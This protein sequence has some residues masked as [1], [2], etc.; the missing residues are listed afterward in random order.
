MVWCSTDRCYYC[1][2]CYRDGCMP[3]H[4][5]GPAI[6]RQNR[7]LGFV[8]LLMLGPILA[9]VGLALVLESFVPGPSGAVL[10][11]GFVLIGAPGF[12]A[13]WFLVSS[14]MREHAHRAS[15][16]ARPPATVLPDDTARDP[17]LPWKP[18]QPTP[19][20]TKR[21]LIAVTIFCVAAAVAL[22]AWFLAVGS[23]TL[24]F[25]VAALGGL[26]LAIATVTGF[27]ASRPIAVPSAV[28]VAH[29]GIHFSYD[30]PYD[31]R[32]QIP[33]MPWTE[34]NILGMQGP[35]LGDPASRLV[36][37]FRIDG[38][39]AQEITRAWESR[40]LV[41]AAPSRPSPPQPATSAAPPSRG[42]PP[43]AVLASRAGSGGPGGRGVACARCHVLFPGIEGLRLL[44]CK[45]DRF[46]VCRRCW[47]DGCQEGHGRGVRSVSKTSRVVS[48]AVVAALFFALW[49]PG[50]AY[51]DSLTNAW[52]YAPVT[53]IAALHAGQ[54][55]KVEGVI[56]SDGLIAFGGQEIIQ[57][58]S[59]NWEWNTFDSFT[60]VDLTGS[61][62]VSTADWYIV[63]NGPIAAPN[64]YHVQA[65]DYVPGDYVQIVGTVVAAANG[66]LQLDLQIIAQSG[67]VGFITLTPSLLSALMV[68]LLPAAM[69]ASLVAGAAVVL[70]RR[71]QHRAATR[72]NPTYAIS[73]S[74]EVRDPALAW[75]PNGRGT[76]PRRRAGWAAGL[77]VAGVA[78][79]AVYPGFGPRTWWGMFSL[80]FIGMVVLMFETVAVYILLFGG[81]GHPTYVAVADDGFHMWFDSP[82]DRHLNDTIFPWDQIQKIFLTGGK[83]SHWVLKWTTGETTN[84]YMLNGSNLHLLMQEW[85]RRNLPV[86]S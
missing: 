13:A 39:N 79:L 14:R 76:N 57:G 11:F 35:A 80:G 44:W 46:Y 34:L 54:V 28:A 62:P 15:L 85:A 50:F 36:R 41:K 47:E 12:A 49:Y 2:E 58:G 27:F 19:P 45:V 84:L 16:R 86:G 6:Q 23:S 77:T 29:D 69:V 30:S 53:D 42:P 22:V 68:W 33:L 64:A 81:V 18:N 72:S 65:G 55:A 24:A 38:Q 7:T 73:S 10:E 78:L 71:S 37:L 31:R 82:Y 63:Y 21:N 9:S 3:V 59:W 1:G 25:S 5:K 4:G 26:L 40:N 67:A 48:A 83:A 74:D 32:S 43:G 17:S 51:D 66:A 70:R 75:Q 56:Q 60:L 61:I 20:R 8:L 52:A